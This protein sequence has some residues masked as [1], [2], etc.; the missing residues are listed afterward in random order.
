[1]SAVRHQIPILMYHSISNGLGPT[2]TSPDVFARQMQMID[3]HGWTI[4]SLDALTSWPDIKGL[5]DK[6]MAITFDDGFADF[7]IHAHPVLERHGFAN[8]MFV[9]S[10]NDGGVES[11]AGIAL[12]GRSLMTKSDLRQLDQTLTKIAPHSRT[13]ADLTLLDADARTD[14]IAGSKSDMEDL[15]GREM[16]H[17]AAPYGRV[18]AAVLSEIR[19]H[20]KLAVG[21]THGVADPRHDPINLPRIEMFYYQD[22]ARWRDFLTGKG[23]AFLASRQVIRGVRKF[24]RGFNTSRA[25]Y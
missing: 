16:P 12:P 23:G 17:F 10:S 19:H 22:L 14:E 1:M 20:F 5:P 24:F 13:H 9:P 4:V 7:L 11:W 3:E 25:G 15:L 2:C 6:S 21:V 8:T 18:N